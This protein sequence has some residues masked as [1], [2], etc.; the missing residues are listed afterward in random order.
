MEFIGVFERQVSFIFVAGTLSNIGNFLFQLYMLRHLSE[1]EYGILY[2]LLAL[3]MIV[4][5]PGATIH[6]VIT[7]YTAHFKALKQYGKIR[8]LLLNL[9]KRL[10]AYGFLG[11]LIFLVASGRIATWQ[12]FPSSRPVMI[13]G[14]LLL[15][16]VIAPAAA[17]IM[18][19]LQKFTY[20]GWT[21]ILG[22]AF[23]LIFGVIFV[24]F[25][26]GV[27]GAISASGLAIFISIC[28]L[29]FPLKF[30]F[31]SRERE[32]EVD[33]K[34]IYR[35]AAPVI[36]SVLFFMVLT[37]FD[38][39]LVGNFFNPV[40]AGIYSAAAL[41]GRAILFLPMAIVF[42]M[43]PKTAELYAQKKDSSH[44]L[45]KSLFY[46]GLLAGGATLFFFLFSS[47][48]GNFIVKFIWSG[49]HQAG[50]P[51]LGQFALAM[52]FFGLVNI[53]F[54][55]QLSIHRFKYLYWT[56]ALT[57]LQIVA[58]TLFHKTLS[59]V[60]WILV[61]NGALLFVVNQF[62]V[63]MPQRKLKRIESERI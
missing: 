25:G 46:V 45:K 31:K 7:R 5:V 29:F 11:L 6:T 54:F 63:W 36:L 32:G 56:G 3:L 8:F 38:V 18:Q 33:F 58:I 1:T 61:A 28:I 40:E 30:L 24:S 50:I 53:L 49:K 9:L 4:S 62:L 59:Q 23:R 57:L 55:Y 19:G 20:F 2:R 43:F 44:I 34:E 22:T 13:L 42:V 21:T 12:H 39:L 17:G 35:Y 60:V 15:L 14:I 37:N 52:T 27:N 10:F 51:L 47:F 26:L 48:I 41:M 16:T